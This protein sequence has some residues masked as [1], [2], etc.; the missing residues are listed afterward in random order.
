MPGTRIVLKSGEPDPDP[1]PYLFLSQVVQ[2][3]V[4]K[5]PKHIQVENKKQTILREIIL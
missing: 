5:Y 1:S 3:Y 2:I 4:S